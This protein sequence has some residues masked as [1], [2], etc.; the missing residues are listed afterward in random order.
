MTH[1]S[2][3]LR[4]FKISELTRVIASQLILTSR[5]SAVNFACTRRCLEEP[6]LSTIWETQSSLPILLKVLPETTW[7]VDSMGLDCTV[8][9]LD[10]PVE[11]SN[12]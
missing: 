1:D 8:C 12:A 5:E 7:H 9:G 6:V 4:V 11:K 2:T 10:P 3:P